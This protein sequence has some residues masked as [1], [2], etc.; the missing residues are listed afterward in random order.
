MCYVVTSPMPLWLEK[1]FAFV[2]AVWHGN[3]CYMPSCFK[4]P[5]PL[6]YENAPNAF[7]SFKHALY[8][9]GLTEKD[10]SLHSWTTSHVLL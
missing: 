4:Y 6:W 9:F 8:L 5:L 10:L 3:Q 1:P 2:M 7:V